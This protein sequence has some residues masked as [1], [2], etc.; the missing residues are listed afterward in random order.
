MADEQAAELL[1]QLDRLLLR[2]R[3]ALLHGDLDEIGAMTAQK[4]ALVQRLGQ[5]RDQIPHDL[6]ARREK[7]L[8][9]QALLANAMQGIR[10]VESRLA[11]LRRLRA[12]LETYDRDGRRSHVPAQRSPR[13]EKRV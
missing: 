10:A 3:T 6:G 9:N 8:R 2:E 7:L 1:E 13:V 11:A 5:Q 12:G 4:Q